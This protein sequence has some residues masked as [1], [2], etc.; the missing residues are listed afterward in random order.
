M[1]QLFFLC[2]ET[3]MQL[4]RVPII[5][6]YQS[7]ILKA[8]YFFSDFDHK[9]LS[10]TVAEARSTHSSTSDAEGRGDL[11]R[12]EASWANP[13]TRK[14]QPFKN[15]SCLPLSYALFQKKAVR[16][17]CSSSSKRNT[18]L[19]LQKGL[20]ILTILLTEW[21][22]QVLE[23]QTIHSREQQSNVHSNATSPSPCKAGH[24][25]SDLILSVLFLRVG[26]QFLE[27][28]VL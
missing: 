28:S 12:T 1:H 2:Y 27:Y 20:A 25:G 14:L 18:L 9:L 22:G 26:H 21:A 8:N 23:A 4:H 3:E 11:Y 16:D 5:N 6:F 19:T 13:M 15:T 7:A 10:E 17:F 24:L